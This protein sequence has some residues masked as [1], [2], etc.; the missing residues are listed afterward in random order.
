M[1]RT[2]L[3]FISTIVVFIEAIIIGILTMIRTRVIILEFG[4]SVNAILQLAISLTSYLLLFESG[5]SAAF[6]FKMYQSLGKGSNSAIPKLFNGLSVS[7]NNIFKKMM[8]VSIVVSVGYSFLLNKEG[9]TYL[10]ACL[11]LVIAFVRVISPYPTTIPYRALLITAEKKYITDIIECAKSV[12]T[13]ITELIL[14]KYTKL[15]LIIIL[16]FYILYTFIS[17]Y[18][19]KKL[20][21]QYY[22]NNILNENECDL[23]P[24][25]MTKDILVHRIAG[26]I[27]SNTD[28]V[29]L[30]IFQTLQ[31]VTVFTS[32]FTL[33]NYPVLLI[34]RVIDSMRASLAVKFAKKD[35]NA[36]DIFYMLVTLELFFI[37]CTIPVFVLLGNDFISLWIGSDYITTPINILLVSIVAFHK[38]FIPAIYSMRDAAG[39]FAETKKASIIQAFVNLIVSLILVKSFGITGVLLGTVIS[40]VG[41]IE[42][43]NIKIISRHVF[44]CE[45]RIWLL[46][47][48]NV[49][50]CII[51]IWFQN[52]LL[53]IIPIINGTEVFEFIKKTFIVVSVN[54]IMSV[55]SM[56][57][58]DKTFRQIL[59]Q[60]KRLFM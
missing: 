34:S 54:F 31:S 29:L 47:L 8:L 11:I 26:I 45:R 43:V 17:K 23:E 13:I 35:S 48:K 57:I 27:T 12:L 60:I 30:S 50:L 55:I 9:V 59:K 39:L 42:V 18:I 19:Y 5:M 46:V 36:Q 14:I 28:S 56:S 32:F 37:L 58:F 1:N 25:A 41:I 44:N 22:G 49:C 40:H 38:M 53:N 2:K 3:S 24:V 6:Q 21:I 52:K 4:S 10:E 20:V 15:P 7:M 16:S 33:I 51:F